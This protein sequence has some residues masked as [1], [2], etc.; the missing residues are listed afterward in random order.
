V[1]SKPVAA[2]S[3]ILDWGS[4]GLRGTTG[5]AGAAFDADERI[6][7]F[8][9][10]RD[11][12]EFCRVRDQID[13]AEGGKSI[14]VGS[15][16]ELG[17]PALR[18]EEISEAGSTRYPSSPPPAL[19]ELLARWEALTVAPDPQKR[20][21]EFERFLSDLFSHCGLDPH[22]SFA[23]A[24]EQIDG[25]FVFESE[26]YL[27][28]AKWTASKTEPSDLFA[29]QEKVQRKS[30]F[31]RGLFISVNGFSTHAVEAVTR[32]APSR[33]IMMDGEH[34]ADVVHG[35]SGLADFLRGALRTLATKGLPYTP[36]AQS[37]G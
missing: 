23:I 17:L 18:D 33:F 10:V 24:G 6:L 11:W 12:T 13:P 34:V 3:L 15:T 4:W 25:S 14:H 7:N 29:F 26:V 30:Q 31:T 8:S 16:L 22:P 5:Q 32:G 20:G 21:H 28:E 9:G 2:L 19:G 36:G 35:R 1:A 27:V 37:G